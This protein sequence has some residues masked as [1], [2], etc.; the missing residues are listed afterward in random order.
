M[1]CKMFQA[2]EAQFNIDQRH[3]HPYN[4]A[5]LMYDVEYTGLRGSDI[6]VI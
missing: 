1:Y 2:T 5:S 3:L 4:H 6:V